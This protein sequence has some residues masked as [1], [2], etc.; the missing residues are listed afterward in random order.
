M[1]FLLT[2][3]L[4]VSVLILLF[5]IGFGLVS[6]IVFALGWLLRLV[7]PLTLF[8]SAILATAL[9]ALAFY[10]V[11]GLLKAFLPTDISSFKDFSK[12]DQEDFAQVDYKSI[13]TNRF[14]KNESE[15]TWEA[16]LRREIANDVYL[17]FQEDRDI[18]RNMNEGQ[19]QE[20][21]IRLAE[22]GV[23]LLK[24]KTS[25][26]HDLNVNLNMLKREMTRMGQRAYDDDILVEAV[27]AINL[28]TDYYDEF[29]TTV[30]HEQSWKRLATI[31]DD[32]G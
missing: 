31:P 1:K 28:N 15:R 16:W 29:L 7:F 14:Y 5:L 6:L 23:S 24:R 25:R 19:Q 13:A 17:R 26:S 30:I 22:V 11:T 12:D 18:V 21:A 32:G 2:V 20:L 10:T 27:E 9:A 4:F 8:E 3:L